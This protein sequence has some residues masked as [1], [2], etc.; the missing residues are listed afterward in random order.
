V[1]RKR[2]RRLRRAARGVRPRPGRTSGGRWASRSDAPPGGRRIRAPALAGDAAR[3]AP[4][5]A[6][7][8][9]IRGERAARAVEAKRPRPSAVRRA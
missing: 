3:E 6:A 8:G 5:I 4:A 2:A 9:G 7:D 1:D